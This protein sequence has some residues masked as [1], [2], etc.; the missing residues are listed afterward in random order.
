M[1]CVGREVQAARAVLERPAVD[2][3]RTIVLGLDQHRAQIT[4]E[5]LDTASGEIGRA[6]VAPAHRE[7]LRRFL[8]RFRGLR[9]EAALEA[10]KGWRFVASCA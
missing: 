7:G 1:R 9:I 3:P 5:W 8:G 2:G 6:R 4:A 10:T